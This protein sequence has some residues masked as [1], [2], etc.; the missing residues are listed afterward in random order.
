MATKLEG[1]RAD[2]AEVRRQIDATVNA[3]L[4]NAEIEARA[5]AFVNQCSDLVQAKIISRAHFLTY[6]QNGAKG[7]WGEVWAVV[8]DDAELAF[9]SAV[10]FNREAVLAN[11]TSAALASVAGQQQEDQEGRWPK[12]DVL[13]AKLLALEV[14]EEAEVVRLETIMEDVTRR[15]EADPYAVLGLEPA[16]QSSRE[17]Y[18]AT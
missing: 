3:R 11:L 5:R 14:E 6:R 9:A 1:L 7:P 17:L 13:R 16:A 2:I 12:V 18:Q 8:R 15:G 4:T 10:H